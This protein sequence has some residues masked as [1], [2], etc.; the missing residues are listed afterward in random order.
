MNKKNLLISISVIAI[1]IFITYF[2]INPVL[3]TQDDTMAEYLLGS[4]FSAAT[5]K[6]TYF[7]Y[8]FL[9]YEK[10]F[11]FLYLHFQNINWLSLFYILLHTV[12]GTAIIYFLI[13]RKRTLINILSIAVYL[14]LFFVP[15]ITKL[16]YTTVAGHSMIACFF[17]FIISIIKKQKPSAKKMWFVFLLMPA[18]LGLRMH[19]VLPLAAIVLPFF[20]FYKKDIF[21]GKWMIAFGC[22]ALIIYCAFLLHKN[23]YQKNIPAWQNI[24]TVTNA[25]Y[26]LGNYGFDEQKLNLEKDSFKKSAF[27]IISNNYLYDDTLLN[28]NLLYEMKEVSAVKIIGNKAEIYWLF[29]DIKQF[30]ILLFAGILLIVFYIKDKKLKAVTLLANAAAIIVS[31]YLLLFMKFPERIWVLIFLLLFLIIYYPLQE[32]KMSFLTKTT[33]WF[34]CFFTLAIFFIQTKRIE[35]IKEEN[36]TGI[37]KFI[38]ANKLINSYPG[39]LFVEYNENYPFNNFPAFELPKKYPF[40]NILFPFFLN[41][42]LRLNTLKKFGFDNLNNALCVSNKIIFIGK[43]NAELEDYIFQTQHK[44]LFFKQI[45]ST[46]SCLSLYKVDSVK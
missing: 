36:K 1:T 12:S 10:C 40:N 11:S 25:Q 27:K 29:T 17:I 22:A 30:L 7:E 15:L 23:D 13:E 42:E 35:T 28:A 33:K 4:G 18:A 16:S 32:I 2:F 24:K 41:T 37:E 19:I 46:V 21:F 9:F 5:L 26:D 31:G 3:A 38:C 39:N 43:P 6:V 8:G 45:D 34:F 20:F 44:K 14:F